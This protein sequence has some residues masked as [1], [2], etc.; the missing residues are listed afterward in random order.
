MSSGGVLVTP[1]QENK[2]LLHSIFKFKPTSKLHEYICKKSN[3][4]KKIFSLAE[5]NL[6]YM[7]YV[8]INC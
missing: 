2:S 5:V 3:N 4:E 1:I 6:A 7:S 8:L